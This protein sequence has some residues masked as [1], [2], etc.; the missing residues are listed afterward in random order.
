MYTWQVHSG[1]RLLWVKVSCLFYWH[2]WLFCRPY[3]ILLIQPSWLLLLPGTTKDSWIPLLPP[4]CNISFMLVVVSYFLLNGSCL[5]RCWLGAPSLV[6]SSAGTCRLLQS[7]SCSST[8][9][10]FATGS[11]SSL[12]LLSVILLF[13]RMATRNVTP[14]FLQS[15]RH[16]VILV[17]V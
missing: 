11:H 15:T 5:G 3:K 1:C 8:L 14:L 10:I 9:V 16:L 13:F 7:G 6:T 12:T 17:F 4:T 2:R